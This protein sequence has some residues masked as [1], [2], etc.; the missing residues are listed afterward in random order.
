VGSTV[1]GPGHVFIGLVTAK[2]QRSD[3]DVLLVRVNNT[4][5]WQQGPWVSGQGGPTVT[6]TGSTVSPVGGQVR[7]SSPINGILTGV[8]SAR[9]V[10]I[11]H[12]DGQL[13]GLTRTTLCAT[14]GDLGA[15]VYAG[16]QAQGYVIA[17]SS[18][19]QTY[20]RPINPALAEYG[21]QL[22]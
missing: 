2:T 10:T 4:E 9:N 11:N 7:M 8:V 3:V 18:G 1:E 5:D 16:G 6:I 15:P 19:C 17:A 12:A 21:I 14:A 20:L 13:T 22:F